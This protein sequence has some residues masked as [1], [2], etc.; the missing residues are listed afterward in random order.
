M[1]PTE[2]VMQQGAGKFAADH[3]LLLAIRVHAAYRDNYPRLAAL[4]KR[5]N[6]ND[7]F[8]LS[9]NIKPA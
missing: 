5:Y 6:P 8:R 1:N 2:S 4:K 9:A 7:L 3:G